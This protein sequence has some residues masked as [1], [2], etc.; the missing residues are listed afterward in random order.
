MRYEAKMESM[1]SMNDKFIMC[2]NI[3][4]NL[5]HIITSKSIWDVY[6]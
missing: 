5:N 3:I 2:K 4:K 6:L 1:S